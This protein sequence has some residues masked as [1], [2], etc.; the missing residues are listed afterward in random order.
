MRPARALFPLLTVAAA[1]VG[2]VSGQF[3]T[4]TAPAVRF[5]VFFSNTL[6]FLIPPAG[7]LTYPVQPSSRTSRRATMMPQ[8][9]PPVNRRLS[10]GL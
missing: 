5:P 2:V 9:L 8:P 4:S 7:Q 10:D 3:T 1:G 6:S